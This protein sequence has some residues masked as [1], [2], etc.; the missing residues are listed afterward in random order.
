MGE[1]RNRGTEYHFVNEAE[2][3]EIDDLLSMVQSVQRSIDVESKQSE[4]TIADD[5]LCPIC[6]S[7]PVSA[8]FVP[9]R[10]KSCRACITQY[11]YNY[12]NCFFC[13]TGIQEVV[14]AEPE[15]ETDPS[16]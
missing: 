6:Y 5:D 12:K 1:R 2:V 8:M 7:R 13:K 9:C 15:P 14:D 4:A 11:L 16:T 3:K 10:H